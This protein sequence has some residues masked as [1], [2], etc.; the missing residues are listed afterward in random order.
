MQALAEEIRMMREDVR[1]LRTEVESMSVRLGSWE[2]SMRTADRKAKNALRREQYRKAKK[3]REEGM[4]PLPEKRVLMFRNRALEPKFAEWGEVGMRFAA[5]GPDAKP[6]EFVTW[7][8]H[9]WNSCTYLKKPITFSGSTFRV[10]DGFVRRAWGPRDLMHFSEPANAVGLFRN[11]DQFDDFQKRPWWDWSYAVLSPVYDWMQDHGLQEVAG[12]TR[13]LRCLQLLLGAQRGEY[14]VFDGLFWDVRETQ[15]NVNR[16][17]RKVG[18]DLQCMLRAVYTGLRVK[19]F[20]SPVQVP[21]FSR[22][23]AAEAVTPRC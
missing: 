16:M 3:R 23:Q 12:G 19:G 8:V 9:Q 10:W 22:P 1:C 5:R 20:E 21:P 7:L 13:F 6:E 11:P 17:L 18:V 2:E 14:E 15:E 4:L